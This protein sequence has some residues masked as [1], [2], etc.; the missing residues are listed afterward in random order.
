VDDRLEGKAK[1]AEGK[2]QEGWG[3][4]KDKTGDAWD[5][6]KDKA[7][8]AWEETKDALDDLTDDDDRVERE[9]TADRPL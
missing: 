5:E 4:L 6:A 2:A 8:D 1:Q 9:K 7:D 3:D